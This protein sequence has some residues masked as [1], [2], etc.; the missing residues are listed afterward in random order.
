[1]ISYDYDIIVMSFI[2]HIDIIVP[3]MSYIYDIIS[4]D[5]DIIDLCINTI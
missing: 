2:S 4:S 1:M 5:Y 3:M